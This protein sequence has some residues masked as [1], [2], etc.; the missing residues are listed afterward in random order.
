MHEDNILKAVGMLLDPIVDAP[1]TPRNSYMGTI[2]VHLFWM[3]MSTWLAEQHRPS[4][5][6]LLVSL[7]FAV[8]DEQVSSP[9]KS[10]L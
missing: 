8:S 4:E 1:E 3:E 5:Q 6:R 2:K 9:E 7:D 10:V